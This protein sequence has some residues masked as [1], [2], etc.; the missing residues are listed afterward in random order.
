[1]WSSFTGVAGPTLAMS[2]WCEGSFCTDCILLSAGFRLQIGC[3]LSEEA[4]IGSGE[5]SR[6]L[7]EMMGN[8]DLVR[9]CCF[10]FLNFNFRTFRGP[11]PANYYSSFGHPTTADLFPGLTSTISGLNWELPAYFV[12]MKNL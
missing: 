6:F 8:F 12:T 4:V 10:S 11:K 2:C 3:R 9:L 1:M 7:S 5:I